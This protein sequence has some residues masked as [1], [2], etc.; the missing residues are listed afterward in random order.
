MMLT[1]E[2]SKVFETQPSDTIVEM[3]NLTK[4]LLPAFA[5]QLRH[6]TPQTGVDDWVLLENEADGQLIEI[7][8]TTQASAIQASFQSG[9]QSIWNLELN[10]PGKVTR[11]HAEEGQG[12]RLVQILSS[13]FRQTAQTNSGDWLI[14]RSVLDPDIV[15]VLMFFTNQKK[16][17]QQSTGH[18][19]QTLFDVLAK[20]PVSVNVQVALSGFAVV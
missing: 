16:R 14:C 15:W 13:Q 2:Q 3:D 19:S 6:L 10:Q 1:I 9:S 18:M 4:D 5:N 11:F 8:L 20:T 7:P 12:E 17:T